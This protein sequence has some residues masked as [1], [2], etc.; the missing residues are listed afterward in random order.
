MKRTLK[1]EVSAANVFDAEENEVY[2]MYTQERR[3]AHIEEMRGN[4][5][6]WFAGNMEDGASIS[7]NVA[8]EEA[9][10]YGTTQESAS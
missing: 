8:V 3:A 5:E 9:L 7:V 4:I 2:G 1:I 10:D 6:K